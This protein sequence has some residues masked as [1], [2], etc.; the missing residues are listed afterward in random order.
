ME[1]KELQK[2]VAHANLCDD[3]YIDAHALYL[4]THQKM[5]SVSSM[6]QVDFRKAF[7]WIKENRAEWIEDIY[8]YRDYDRSDKKYEYDR[9]IIILKNVPVML[10]LAENFIEILHSENDLPLVEELTAG[11]QPFRQGQKRK[12][13][14]INLVVQNKGSMTLRS[15]EIKRTKLDLGLYYEPDFAD[16]D[17]L[18][19]K[20]LNT[21]KDKGLVLL[22]GKP[23]TGKTTYLRHLTGRL[24]KRILF[25]P[26]TVAQEITGPSFIELLMSYP[27]SVLVIEDA[28]NILADRE[29][30]ENS[31]VSNL[32]NL[33]DGLLADCLNVQVICT[34]NGALSKIDSALLRKGRLIAQYEFRELSVQ[35]AQQLSAHLG[36]DTAISR[37]MSIAEIANQ[38]ERTFEV[39]KVQPIGFRAALQS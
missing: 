10:V 35:K 2:I 12:A 11:L 38:H 16:I 34:F 32:L 19:L 31:S 27:N 9:I 33:S 13:H 22:H 37:P 24:K 7:S 23:G 29:Q 20:R 14:E 18:I 17:R 21:S 6:Y 25:L 15:M 3:F 30:S 4:Q 5:P 8:T 39:K 36:F 28:E 1:N 26:P